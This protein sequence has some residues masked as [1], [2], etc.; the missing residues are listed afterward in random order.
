MRLRLLKKSSTAVDGGAEDGPLTERETATAPDES[1][2]ERVEARDAGLVRISRVTRL[3]VAGGVALSCALAVVASNV[4]HGSA[5]ASPTAQA[6]TASDGSPQLW[7][8]SQGPGTT[9]ATAAII[10]GAS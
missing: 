8:P 1:A 2:T 4:I 7:A 9:A 10:S 5:S 3:L 6:E